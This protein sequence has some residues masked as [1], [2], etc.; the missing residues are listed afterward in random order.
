MNFMVGFI[1]MVSGCREKESFWLF[2]AL[3]HQTDKPP[4]MAGLNGL[5]SSGFKLLLK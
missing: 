4:R 3:L 5:Y 1:L 2:A